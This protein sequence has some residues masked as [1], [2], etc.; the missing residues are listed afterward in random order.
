[1]CELLVVNPVVGASPATSA[2]GL[3]LG[4]PVEHKVFGAGVV[5]RV[6]PEAVTVL[7]K[8]AGYKVLSTQL[9]EEKQL[10]QPGGTTKSP[11]SRGAER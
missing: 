10:L 11:R 6:T 5:Q 4:K 9:I 3:A 2:G 1:M 7:F 8:D